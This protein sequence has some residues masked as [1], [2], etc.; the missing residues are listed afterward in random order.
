M[1]TEA[2][3]I[4]GPTG[5]GKTEAAILVAKKLNGEIISADS[6]QVYRGMDIGTAK[7]TREQLA[8][9]PHHLID[10]L[11]LDETFS[12]ARFKRLAEEKTVEIRGRGHVPLVVGGT[13]LYVKSLTEGIFEGPSADWGLRKKLRERERE[14]GPGHLYEELREVDPES[15]EKIK[16]NDMRRVVRALEIYHLT[17]R[18]ISEHQKEWAEKKCDVTMLGFDME[19]DRLYERIN[20]RVDDMFRLGL[21]DETRRLMEQGIERN[22]TAMQAIGYKEIIGHIRGEYP[23]EKAN[24]LLKRNS[25]RYARRQLTWFRKDE[26]IRWFDLGERPFE[27]VCKEVMEFLLGRGYNSVG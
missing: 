3:F 12:A 16:P 20:R 17:G 24:E 15:A 5:V 19:R 11:E 25:R 21:V 26:R 13:G 23:I 9:V 2:I 8:E 18:P 10:V 27:E 14:L 6:M 7:P 22:R 4:V 1:N